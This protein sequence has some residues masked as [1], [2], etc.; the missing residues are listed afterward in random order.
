M[1]KEQEALIPII[2]IC[3]LLA[4]IIPLSVF[5][6]TPEKEPVDTPIRGCTDSTATNFDSQAT[7][8][9]GSCVYT[10]VAVEGCMDSNATN[11]DSN[12]TVSDGGCIYPSQPVL[13]CTNSDA[14][15]FND[16][17]TDDDGSC[18]FPPPPIYGC[19]DSNAT[20]YDPNAT[21]DDGT[22]NFPP[23]P[24][25]GCTDSSASNFNPNAT[26]DDGS[27]E[28][29]PQGC[30]DVNA[31]N[32]DPHAEVDDGSCTYPPPEVLGCMDSTADNYDQ[33]ATVDDGSC[34]YPPIVGCTYPSAIN[35][36]PLAVIFDDSCEFP[37][38][39]IG[40][41]NATIEQ[42][43]GELR[44]L[45]MMGL[46]AN[47]T[48]IT[49]T[50]EEVALMD[51]VTAWYEDASFG[52][53]TFNVTYTGWFTVSSQLLWKPD[54][55]EETLA[56]GYDLSQYDLF[57]IGT[58]QFY[59][60]GI[61]AGGSANSVGVGSVTR[62]LSNGTVLQLNGSFFGTYTF[63]PGNEGVMI[64]EFGH[65]LGF[66]HAG[67]TQGWTGLD[68]AYRN[69]EDVMGE[70][71][72]F[73]H[74]S[75]PSKAKLGWIAEENIIT[76]V[77]NGTWFISDVE[78]PAAGGIRTPVPGD[79]TGEGWYWI[80]SRSAAGNGDSTGEIIQTYP[81]NAPRV[82]Y[83]SAAFLASA[84]TWV[85]DATPE[86]LTNTSGL[87]SHLLPSRTWSDPTGTIHFTLLSA[88]ETGIL[89]QVIFT[90]ESANNQAPIVTN[91]TATID[92]NNPFLVHY[93]VSAYDPEGN[94]VT[95][96]W[97]PVNAARFQQTYSSHARYDSGFS[98]SKE[99][100]NDNGRRVLLWISDGEGGV[101]R[102]WIDVFGYNNTAP[103]VDNITRS[104]Y[105]DY[106]VVFFSHVDD[107]DLCELSWDF[108][109]G[110]A[111]ATGY[112]PMHTYAQAGTYTVTLTVTDGEFSITVT[113][114]VNVS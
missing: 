81:H 66:H 76:T 45:V 87:D 16:N 102:T 75:A 40:L 11:Y 91:L 80:G 85:I 25:H 3:I 67:F 106:L 73:G 71:Y 100:N 86:T 82:E 111:N 97:S 4:V 55:W 88:N 5:D 65:C 10:V 109:D 56:L 32:F 68:H 95:V 89:V 35:Y 8:D 72:S 77:S 59:P 104:I 107:W 41:D 39:Q 62:T 105:D 99:Y 61:S 18:I 15:N 38:P 28:Y 103:I 90:N 58:Q 78:T 64:H 113:R 22:C 49:T 31:T 52:H 50:Q 42:A 14:T 108:G 26:D 12:A 101:T 110:S 96:F 51:Y 69:G 36:D 2:V 46:L 57:V 19:T 79:T 54:Y 24:V 53:L 43:T 23:P 30:M 92:A 37:G 7:E 74:F 60:P 17:A 98:I 9:D 6:K 44:I 13:G 94:N 63:Q 21:S 70:A 93:N 47:Q 29:P 112:T 20:N 1:E 48:P 27:C 34:T 84:D 33:N 83:G 114:V